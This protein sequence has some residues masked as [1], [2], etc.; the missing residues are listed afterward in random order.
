MKRA[1]ELA[2]ELLKVLEEKKEECVNVEQYELSTLNPGEIFKIGEHD[3]IVL[4]QME[5]QTAVI[6]KGFMAE[7]K[8][9]DEETRDYNKSAIKRFI[10]SEIQPVI[11]AAVGA[12]NLVEHEVDLTSVDMQK[13]FENC[14][15]K[16]RLITFDEA[17]KYNDLVADK[18]LGDLWWT[19]TPWSTE[20]RGYKYLLAVV[21]PSGCITYNFY[22]CSCGVRPF[23]IL[24]SN[25]FVSKGG[26]K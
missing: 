15:C 3:F 13:E 12:D 4:E 1:L 11:E 21:F 16:V 7:D 25:I 23:C 10:E 9:F 2:K 20:E 24:K 18:S 6:S 26:Q 22:D 17:R 5:G 19:C 14:R 8:Q